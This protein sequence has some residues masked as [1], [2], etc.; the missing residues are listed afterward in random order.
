MADQSATSRTMSNTL[1]VQQRTIRTAEFRVVLE[2]FTLTLTAGVLV[3]AFTR[4]IAWRMA[5]SGTAKAFIRM[6][7]S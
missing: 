1:L 6:R 2:Q 5:S 7:R 4:A 3:I